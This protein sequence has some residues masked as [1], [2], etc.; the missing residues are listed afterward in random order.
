VTL[1]VVIL[2]PGRAGR[3]LAAALRAAG[4]EVLGLVGRRPSGGE[5]VSA[6]AAADVILVTVKDGDQTTALTGLAERGLKPGAVVLHASGATDPAKALDKLRADGHP[7]GTFHPLVG[8]SDP[9]TAAAVL[10]GAWIGV[11][12]DPAAVAASESLT[13]ALG[14][15]VLMIPRGAKPGYHAAAVI[16]ANFPAVLAAAAE[17]EM[18]HAGIESGPARAAVA[19]LMK[20]SIDHVAS[21]GPERAL[22][23]PVSRGD[24]GT[25]VRNLAAVADDRA[26]HDLYVAATRVAIELARAAGTT[27]AENLDAIARALVP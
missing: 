10:R 16:A 9:S 27:S 25:V 6:F 3:A 22:T 12:G 8:L 19:H 18:R 7:A 1:K 23:G 4:I 21:L 24:V 14:G 15:H 11:D 13:S 20:A 17:R 5:H 26:L 2:G